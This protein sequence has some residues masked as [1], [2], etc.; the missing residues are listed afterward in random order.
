MSRSEHGKLNCLLRN[1]PYVT[2]EKR[3]FKFAAGQGNRNFTQAFLRDNFAAVGPGSS[4]N[5]LEVEDRNEF[6]QGDRIALD[7]IVRM[8]EDDL[9]LLFHGYQVITVGRVAGKYEFNPDG[10]LFGSWDLFHTRRVDWANRSDPTVERVI[11][12]V[13]PP[14][15]AEVRGRIRELGWKSE[16]AKQWAREVDHG[17][18]AVGFWD[19]PL[20]ALDLRDR[21]RKLDELRGYENLPPSV[22]EHL[23]AVIDLA[24]RLRDDIEGR[25][26]GA[27]P[28][29]HETVA[30]LVVPFLM[31]LGWNRGLVALEWNRIDVSVFPTI[32]RDEP[33]LLIEAKRPGSGLDWARGQAG[34]YAD[35]KRLDC[36]IMT[37][38]GYYWALFENRNHEIPDAELFLP[39]IR[40]SANEFFD[41][42]SGLDLLGPSSE[43]APWP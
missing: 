16:K 29:E 20:A 34:T 15:K 24:G 42:I 21:E 2:E 32:H 39:D 35:D 30:H 36:P 31:A 9:V 14:P 33:E 27:S 37:T 28:S 17:L 43:A 22:Q 3:V 6:S 25:G 13:G 1:E 19:R 7:L 4:G 11:A 10:R 18:E 41:L 23:A 12:E 40:E 38:D 8:S 5:W 26:W